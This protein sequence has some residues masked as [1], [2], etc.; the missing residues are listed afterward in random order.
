MESPSA[1]SSVKRR[2]FRVLATS[3]DY[4]A[5][6]IWADDEDNAFEIG[7]DLDGGLFSGVDS[8]WTITSVEPV[9]DDKPFSPVND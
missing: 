6:D 5:A 7:Q 9:A 2:R 1:S 4:L 3:T 8:N